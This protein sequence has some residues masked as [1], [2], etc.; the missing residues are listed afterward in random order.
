MVKLLPTLSYWAVVPSFVLCSVISL[1]I[2]FTVKRRV[3]ARKPWRVAGCVW[4]GGWVGCSW[5]RTSPNNISLLA[6]ALAVLFHFFCVPELCSRIAVTVRRCVSAKK[7]RVVA[8]WEWVGGWVWVVSGLVGAYNN[9]H[10]NI[11][12]LSHVRQRKNK[13]QVYQV[14][15]SVNCQQVQKNIN[16]KK[17]LQQLHLPPTFIL[18]L[19][20]ARQRKNLGLQCLGVCARGGRGVTI[21]L[22]KSSE[23]SF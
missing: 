15:I 10:Q 17:G 23:A 21:W 6:T 9:P 14:S 5:M 20:H 11:S 19:R 18:L 12:L 8:R 2:D 3:S 7:T 13:Y 16:T 1:G 22:F 4:V